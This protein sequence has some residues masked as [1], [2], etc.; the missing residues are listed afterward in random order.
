MA[1]DSVSFGS[2]ISACERGLVLKRAISQS[3]NHRPKCRQCLG[4]GASSAGFDEASSG[5]GDTARHSGVMANANPP[6]IE[7]LASLAMGTHA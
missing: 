1:Q 3:R 6:G 5:G 7:S 4:D 2:A